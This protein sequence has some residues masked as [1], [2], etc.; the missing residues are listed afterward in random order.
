MINIRV[1][2]VG[3]FD[4]MRIVIDVPRNIVKEISFDALAGIN[5]LTTSTEKLKAIL[6]LL[7][8]LEENKNG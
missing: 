2:S 6:R 3:E 5:T 7:D 8:Q 4:D 1:M